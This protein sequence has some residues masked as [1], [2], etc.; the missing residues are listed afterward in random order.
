[1]FEQ[2]VLGMILDRE[3]TGYDI[4][5][6]IEGSIGKFYKASHGKLYPTLK[7]LTDK[8]FLTM[9]E[10][11]QGGRQKK[12]YQ[13]TVLGRANFLDWL[14][15]PV[16]RNVD[17]DVQLA[18]IF[19]YGELPRE[20]RDKRLQ[21]YEFYV[22][23]GLEHLEAMEKEL[24]SEN[25]DDKDYYGIATLYFGIQ[26]TQNALYWLGYIR[27]QNPLSAFLRKRD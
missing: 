1:M 16:S 10:Q 6:E 24:P 25:L 26:S 21:E 22:R 19:F 14:S 9:R 5:K 4:K 27:E 23:Q 8:E 2:V 20:L 7:K 11:N 17:W 13:A 15:A 12:Y 3:L 18:K